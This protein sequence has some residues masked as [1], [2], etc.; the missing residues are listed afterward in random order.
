MT[1]IEILIEKQRINLDGKVDLRNVFFEIGN[2]VKRNG[3]TEFVTETTVRETYVGGKRLVGF[4]TIRR[5]ED[6]G[7]A[8]SRYS[9]NE[10]T[11]Q[12]HQDYSGSVYGEEHPPFHASERYSKLNSLLESFEK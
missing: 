8:E 5:E 3:K 9:V 1:A 12:E 10:K 6:R 4:G 11:G 2:K 7:I